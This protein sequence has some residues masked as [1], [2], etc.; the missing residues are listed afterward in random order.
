MN[1][2][3]KDTSVKRA[4][5][6]SLLLLFLICMPLAAE[7]FTYDFHVDK[8][9]PYKNEPIR[10]SVDIR[11][12]NPDVVLF[13]NF[14][15]SPSKAYRV[16]QIDTVQNTTLHHSNIHYLYV[17]YPLKEGPI[18]VTF[19]LVER[20][21]D[22]HKV[23]YSFSGDRDDFKKLETIDHKVEVPPLHLDAKPLPKGTE[24]VGDFTLD[25]EIRQ[26][27]AEAYE[28][29]NMKVVIK[30]EGYPPVLD[31]IFPQEGE[32][33][34][35]RQ[36]PVVKNFPDKKSIRYEVTYTMAVSHHESFTL[37]SVKLHAFNPK[38]EK[39]YVLEIP[40]QHFD[41]QQSDR[42]ILVD[43][44]DTPAPFHLDFEWFLSLLGYLIVFM[45]G[46]FSAGIVKSKKKK[47]LASTHP[48]K[49]KIHR[50]KDE[51]AL[52]Q[53]L[54]AA[55]RQRF[56]PEVEALEN[57]LYRSVNISFKKIKQEAEEKVT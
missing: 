40:E 48:L 31:H 47:E 3:I 2:S 18:D 6:N 19:D 8:P 21:T 39:S 36:P 24:L 25:W 15:V 26:H 32:V 44:S 53:L 13:F 56:A 43:K 46:Y 54:M 52:L 28:P 29:I 1:L 11:Q 51:K 23:A 33:S 50:C 4:L 30:G 27:T 16:V 14:A 42:S 34:F 22:E 7:N 5:G 9:T 41:I 49:E 35:F 12:T 10:L 45:A 17:L 57:G 55:D 20:V 38:T 37:S